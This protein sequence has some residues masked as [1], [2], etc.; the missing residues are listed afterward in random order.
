[1]LF[2]VAIVGCL[3]CSFFVTGALTVSF[4]WHFIVF[5]ELMSRIIHSIVLTKAFYFLY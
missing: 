5:I 4:A 1:M 2:I 3:H